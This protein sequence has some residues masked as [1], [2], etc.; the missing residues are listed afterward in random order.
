MK[1]KLLVLS[2]VLFA[3]VSPL[4][5]AQNTSKDY[6]VRATT[7]I[8][9]SSENVSQKN[10]SYLVQQSIGQASAIGTFY[11]S[12]YI[13]RQ[14]FI[15]PNRIAN[16]IAELPSELEADVY[17]IPLSLEAIVYPNPF[18]QSIH[19]SFTENISSNIEVVVFDV[20]GQHVFSKR[21]KANQKIKI[22]FSNLSVA[23]YFL[24]ITAN[25]KQIIKKI[26][27]N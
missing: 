23:N 12:N 10:N 20:F 26:I 13:L 8:A 3:F 6:L 27:K 11:N 2:V 5:Q 1:Q 9:G 18:I 22:E 25:N 17:K 7:G 21:Y 4:L 24:K 15:Q 14:G 19:I 16:N